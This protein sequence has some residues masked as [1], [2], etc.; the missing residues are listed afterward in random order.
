MAGLRNTALRWSVT[1]EDDEEA[2]DIALPLRALGSRRR[3]VDASDL[4]QCALL[5]T[6]M[7]TSRTSLTAHR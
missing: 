1:E 2:V 7:K 5:H 4:R 6:M 3:A